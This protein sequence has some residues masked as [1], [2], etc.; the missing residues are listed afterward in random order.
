[1]KLT[2]KNYTYSEIKEVLK[3]DE[4]AQTLYPSNDAK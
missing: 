1:M 2:D 3:T 4:F